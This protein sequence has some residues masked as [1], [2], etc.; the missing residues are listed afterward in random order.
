[1]KVGGSETANLIKDLVTKSDGLSSTPG[2]YMVVE[3]KNQVMK[4]SSGVHANK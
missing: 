3:G 4:M 2:T 1:M